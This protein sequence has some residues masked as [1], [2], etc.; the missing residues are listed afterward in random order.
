MYDTQ[1][2]KFVHILIYCNKKKTKSEK[3]CSVYVYTQTEANKKTD[4]I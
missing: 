1:Q 3:V 2:S 4:D